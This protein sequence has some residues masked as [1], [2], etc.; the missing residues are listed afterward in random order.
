MV[1][2]A[3]WAIWHA[4]RK[5]IHEN[6]YQSPLSVHCFVDRFIVDLKQGEKAELKSGVRITTPEARWI[7]PS[8]RV[9]KINVDAVV[10]KNSVKGTVAA[11]AHSDRGVFLGA[12]TVVF[13]GCMD[14][15]TLE[16]LACRE[17]ILLAQDLDARRI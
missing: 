15:E 11:V 7:P 10:G 5:A 4:R 2:V 14:A 9:V 1:F 6:E 3:L 13:P 17:A 12:S 16:T 8:P